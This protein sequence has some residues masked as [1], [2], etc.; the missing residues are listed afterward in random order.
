MTIVEIRRTG[1]GPQPRLTIAAG[2]GR[3]EIVLSPRDVTTVREWVVTRWQ[4]AVAWLVRWGDAGTIT[5]EDWSGTPGEPSSRYTGRAGALRAVNIATVAVAHWGNETAWGQHEYNFNAGG[6]HCFANSPE[7]FE[8]NEDGGSSAQQFV[9]FR[10]FAAFM[11]VY[12]EAVSRTPDYRAAW[13]SFEAGSADGILEL[14]RGDYFCGAMTAREATS[15]VERVVREVSAAVPQWA[16]TFQTVEERRAVGADV[17][18]RCSPRR[19]SD[20]GSGGSS[21]QRRRGSSGV[22]LAGAALVALVLANARRSS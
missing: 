13:R 22:M 4:F 9:A 18:D 15:L 2:N 5:A 12:F 21:G 14:G 10:D 19:A 11:R 8:A 7:C 17:P 3:G 16:P 6:I 1:R 20:G